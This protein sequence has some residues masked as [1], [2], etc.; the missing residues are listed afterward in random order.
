VYRLR[1]AFRR[2][3]VIEFLTKRKTGSATDR[4]ATSSDQAQGKSRPSVKLVSSGIVALLGVRC[5]TLGLAIGTAVNP[6][7]SAPDPFL[8]MR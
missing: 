3:F 4:V 6:R 8:R 5:F 2:R 7:T 1:K